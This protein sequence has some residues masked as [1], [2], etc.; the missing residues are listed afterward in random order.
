V[1]STSDM[2]GE[3]IEEKFNAKIRF[4]GGIHMSE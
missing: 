3:I 2:S 1:I 4:G